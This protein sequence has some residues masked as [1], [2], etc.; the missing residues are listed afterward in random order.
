MP[1]EVTG[2]WKLAMEKHIPFKL[3]LNLAISNLVNSKSPLFWRKIKIWS[4]H[5]MH[6]MPLDLPFPFT[7][8]RLFRSPAISNFFHFP[9]DFEIAGFDCNLIYGFTYKKTLILN[10]TFWVWSKSF[11]V[12]SVKTYIN[13]PGKLISNAKVIAFKDISGQSPPPWTNRLS[14]WSWNLS[15]LVVTIAGPTSVEREAKIWTGP[16]QF[17]I[18][19]FWQK[20]YVKGKGLNPRAEPPCI[21]LC[22]VPS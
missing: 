3:Q 4:K 6:L 22:W 15:G 11:A 5:L 16:K 13:E 17:F 20:W 14:R 19:P 1:G 9:W 8:P 7:L 10:I 12:A 21:N 18:Y 2:N